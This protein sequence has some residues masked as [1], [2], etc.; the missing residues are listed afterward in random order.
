MSRFVVFIR[1]QRH[2]GEPGHTRAYRYLKSAT[3][4]FTFTFIRH[5]GKTHNH[6]QRQVRYR[7]YTKYP[8]NTVKRGIT[9]TENSQGADG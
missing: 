5:L 1:V 3:V 6:R 8:V 7:P 9:A 4:P 2:R